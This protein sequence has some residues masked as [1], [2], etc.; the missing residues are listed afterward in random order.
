MVSETLGKVLDAAFGCLM[1]L[2]SPFEAAPA[3]GGYVRNLLRIPSGGD[4]AVIAGCENGRE[5]LGLEVWVR[6][7]LDGRIMA[8]AD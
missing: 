4:P 3:A 2:V 8:H 5:E 6:L 7:S 1:A